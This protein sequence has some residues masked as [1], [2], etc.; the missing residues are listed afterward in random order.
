MNAKDVINDLKWREDRD[1]AKAKIYYVHRGSPGNE[2]IISGLDIQ[3][4]ENS[5]FST[6]EAMIPYHR[7]FRID[8]DDETIF[9][10]KR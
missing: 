7:I 5:F 8:Y 6:A 4:M 9:Q 10:R 1:L 3:D 2:K